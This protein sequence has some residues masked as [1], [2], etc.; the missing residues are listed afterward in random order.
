[1]TPLFKGTLRILSVPRSLLPREQV[2]LSCDLLAAAFCLA[3]L[4]MGLQTV[5]GLNW[6]AEPDLFRD[7]AQAQTIADGDLLGDSFYRGEVSWYPPLVPGLVAAASRV[8]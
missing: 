7:I 8:R 6:P 2:S 1:V 3:A 4:W 5:Q